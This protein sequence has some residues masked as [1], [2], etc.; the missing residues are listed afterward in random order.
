MNFLALDK[1]KNHCLI[2]EINE[3]KKAD[4]ECYVC[5]QLFKNRNIRDQH[6][7]NHIPRL[8]EKAMDR[9]DDLQSK[10]EGLKVF[11]LIY[12]N[13]DRFTSN[14]CPLCGHV[15]STRKSFKHHVVFQHLLRSQKDLDLLISKLDTINIVEEVRIVRKLIAD[16]GLLWKRQVK[17][18]AEL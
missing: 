7:T 4:N 3:A 2:H 18:M 15:V 11:N 13:L 6:L 1:M 8:I 5:R 10:C 17:Y 16:P 12:I 9:I 14:L